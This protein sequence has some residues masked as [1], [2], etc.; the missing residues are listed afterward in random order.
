MVAVAFKYLK[1]GHDK[2]VFLL[3][4]LLEQLDVIWVAEVVLGETIDIV[5]QLVLALRKGTLRTL[6][7]VY[8]LLSQS[9]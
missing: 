3:D 7:V 2:C 6:V 8:L 4:E 5:H 1:S 9:D